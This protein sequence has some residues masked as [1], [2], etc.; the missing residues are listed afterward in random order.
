MNPFPELVGLELGDGND[1]AVLQVL[2]KI[3]VGMG[4]GD[5]LVASQLS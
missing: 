4:L 1:G 3:D 2:M 5:H